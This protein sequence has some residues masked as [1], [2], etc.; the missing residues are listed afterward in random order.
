M[1]RTLIGSARSL[2]A[3]RSLSGNRFE[4]LGTL[5]KSLNLLT[6]SDYVTFPLNPL[7]NGFNLAFWYKP[8][9]RSTD[10]ILLDWESAAD[11]DGI[12]LRQNSGGAMAIVGSNASGTVFVGTE[13]GKAARGEWQHIVITYASSNMRLY[14]NAG[15]IAG[16]SAGNITSNVTSMRLGS[17]SYTPNSASQS[18]FKDFVFQNTT[19]IWTT[20]EISN[21]YY[22]RKIP[23]GAQIYCKLDNDVLDSSGNGNNG[24]LTG[25][26]YVSDV[27][28]NF[29]PR[30]LT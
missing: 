5:E 4:V 26:A 21:L 15:L 30:S 25:G 14:R 10:L 2:A 29:N 22:K 9:R 16:P 12:N 17:R 28:P 3:A 18:M 8:N 19:T 20:T 24:V 11:R 27:P 23:S 13:T 6:S 7:V 1:L